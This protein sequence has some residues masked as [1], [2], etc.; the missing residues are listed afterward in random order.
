MGYGVA[1]KALWGYEILVVSNRDA[2]T[3]ITSLLRHFHL[4][5]DAFE[6]LS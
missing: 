6:N 2:R 3:I 5:Q 4:F 1:P